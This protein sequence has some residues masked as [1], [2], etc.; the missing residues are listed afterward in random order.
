MNRR[1]IYEKELNPSQLEAVRFNRG[2]LLVIA[3]AGSGKTRTLTYRVARLVDE[4]VPPGSILLLTF[5]RKSAQEMLK[6]AARLLDSR[7]QNVSGGTFHSFAYAVLRRYA[8]EVGFENGFS[9]IDRSDAEDLIGM[10]RKEFMG[11]STHG[12]LPRKQTLTNI[13]SRAANKNLSVEEIVENDY[14]HFFR[15][16]ELIH[17]LS[18]A[19]RKQ[20]IE[21]R[22]MDY[23]D[24]LIYLKM[25]LNE[26][27]DIRDKTCS[28][29]QYLMVDEYQ[30]TNKIQADIVYLLSGKHRNIMV[31]GDDSQS[32]YAFR[33][34]N[35]ENIMR[36]PDIFPETRIIR[37]EENYRSTEPILKLTNVIIDRATRKYSKILFT[38]KTGG[39]PPLLIEAQSENRQSRFLIEK[40]LGIHRSGVPLNQIAVLFRASFHSFDL[41]IELNREGIPFIKVGGGKFIESAHIKDILAHLKVIFN[42]YDRISWYRI[43]LLL[44]HIG[45][46]TALDIYER[47]SALNSGCAGFVHS[48]FKTSRSQGLDT[49]KRLFS[50]IDAEPMSV[51]RL[52]EAVV[53]YYLPILRKKYDDHPKRSRDLEHLVVMMERYEQL[54]SFLTD[55]ALEPPNTSQNDAVFSDTSNDERLVLSTVHSAKGLEWHTVFIIWALDGRFPSIHAVH[56]EKDLEEELR[57]M[58]VAATRARENLFFTYP[59]QIYDRISGM[60]L[61][62]PCRFI[63]N[64]PDDILPKLSDSD[65]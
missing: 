32:I 28:T 8:F 18:K 26:H 29:Y 40:V 14:P 42:P 34:A 62:R 65:L 27:P 6:R 50:D 35:F 10:L 5:T 19:Y 38:R 4:G 43:L 9:I 20:K 52:G 58:Y 63:D 37:L 17:T 21:H 51:A 49:L 57:L 24:L 12:A 25:L 64:I 48:S 39:T 30:D 2:P 23:D 15:Y 45:P 7:C 33:G 1:I 16:M 3:G 55:M 47:I 11:P 41:E 44:D 31:V 22:F 53:R 13:F 61:N 46:K 54:E 36:F 60:V 56:D 59:V